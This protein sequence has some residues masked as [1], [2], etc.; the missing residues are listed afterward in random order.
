MTAVSVDSKVKSKLDFFLGILVA[1]PVKYPDEPY[2]WFAM[3]AMLMASSRIVLSRDNIVYFYAVM[4]LSVLSI[5]ANIYSPFFLEVNYISALA[6]ALVFYFFLFRYCIN[7]VEGFLSG[8][9]FVAKIYAIAVILM[10]FILKPYSSSENFF[11]SSEARMWASGYLPEWP[12][13]FCVF[14]VVS[15]FVFV[16]RCMNFWAFICILSALLTTSRMAVLGFGLFLV[17]LFLRA[18][19]RN[20]IVFLLIFIFSM[21]VLYYYFSDNTRVLDYLEHRLFKTG[22][23]QI[24]FD[25]LYSV[26]IAHPFGVGN[27]SFESLN[28]AYVSYH[29][30][31]LKIAVRYGF[32]SFL[33]FIFLV[34]PRRIH[35]NLLSYSN[36]P[37]LFFIIVGVVQDMLL[38][39]HFILLYGVFLR[40]REERLY[41]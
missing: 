24:I 25:T 37:L 34:F 7:D 4:L 2:Y 17:F 5:F 9:L 28:S 1:V 36:L 3:L 23:R 11:V 26:F 40:Y 14:L 16:I 22:D 32:L 33:V 38:H 12:N 21:I 30:S 13:V 10:F 15:F 19:W 6:S 41:D 8:F 27:L 18:S 39:L 29:S 35:K 31:F 20:K